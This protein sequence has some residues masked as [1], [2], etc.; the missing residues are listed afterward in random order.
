LVFMVVALAIGTGFGANLAGVQSVLVDVWVGWLGG[1]SLLSPRGGLLLTIALYELPVLLVAMGRL[2]VTA[3]R[4]DRTDMFLSLWA[5]VLLLLSM[6]Q[7]S[8]G[9]SRTILPMI[10]IYFLAARSVA[11]ILPSV[12]ESHPTWRWVLG[13]IAIAVPTGVAMVILNRVSLL[14]QDLPSV[15]LYGEAALVLCAALVMALVLDDEGRRALAWGSALVMGVAFLLHTSFFLNFRLDSA[16]S[17]L[18]I[19]QQIS[20]LLRDSATQAA[21]FNS[22]FGSPVTVDPQLRSSLEWYLRTARGVDFSTDESSGISIELG[23]SGQNILPLT[24]ERG[25]G[26]Y[27]PAIDPAK[28]TWQGL[29]GWLMARDGLVKTNQRDI[30]LRAPAGD[31]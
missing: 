19:G 26:L 30:I 5:M 4:R 31:W 17:E 29:W 2:L 12:G 18:V 15:F 11:D 10:P 8:G 28:L 21:Y 23:Q 20:P 16:P 22:Y 9:L 6:L 14:G 13:C 1:F 7:S 25:P 24:S 27:A 3:A